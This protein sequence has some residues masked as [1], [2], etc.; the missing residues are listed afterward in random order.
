MRALLLVAVLQG[1]SLMIDVTSLGPGVYIMPAELDG[2]KSTREW[3]VNGQQP[4]TPTYGR[5]AGV[6]EK[7]PNVVHWFDP[8]PLPAE[9][10]IFPPSLM[11]D[12][13][14]GV[15]RAVFQTARF[16]IEVPIPLP[17]CR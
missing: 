14:A 15:D 4:G 2:N 17:S 9:P 10:Y 5:V 7:C 6:S 1:F 8:R 12:E 13:R 3:V 16:Y 11:R